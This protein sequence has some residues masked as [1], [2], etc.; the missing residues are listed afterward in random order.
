MAEIPDTYRNIVY[1]EFPERKLQPEVDPE[2]EEVE[3]LT[4]KEQRAKILEELMKQ[5]GNAPS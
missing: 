2:A 4:P 1:P 5:S 3:E